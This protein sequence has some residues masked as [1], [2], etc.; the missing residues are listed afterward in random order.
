MDIITMILALDVVKKYI[1][2]STSNLL[3]IDTS[4]GSSTVDGKL[5]S[6]ISSRGWTDVIEV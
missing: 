5:Y 4:A 6:A 1:A 2:S 3:T